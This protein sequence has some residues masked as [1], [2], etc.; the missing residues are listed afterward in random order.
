M[1]GG[2]QEEESAAKEVGGS[3]GD[4]KPVL[5]LHTNKHASN[6]TL[7]DAQTY[8]RVVCSLKFAYLLFGFES[9]RELIAS[10]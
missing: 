7:M 2:G 3:G 1:G 6:Q 5:A 4:V 9:R 8:F 10:D